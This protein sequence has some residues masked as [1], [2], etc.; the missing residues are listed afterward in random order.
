M[1]FDL[2]I[3]HGGSYLGQDRRSRSQVKVNGYMWEQVQ[4]RGWKHFRL[5][6]HVTRRQKGTV[7]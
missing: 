1:T 5:R 2:N 7:G 4:M 3:G 6:T